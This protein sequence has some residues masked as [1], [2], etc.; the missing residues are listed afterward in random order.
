MGWLW[1]SDKDGDSGSSNNDPLKDLDPSLRAFLEKESPVKYKTSEAPPPD[2]TTGLDPRYAEASSQTSTP[3][4]AD[5]LTESAPSKSAFPDG[6]YAHLWSTYKPLSAVEN[7]AKTDQEKLLDV[8]EGFKERKAQIGRAAL[9][10]C[11]EE[12]WTVSECYRSGKVMDRLRLCHAENKS[13][14]RCYNMQAVR[15]VNL[16]RMKTKT[17]V[18]IA[19]PQ[20]FG[21]PFYL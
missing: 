12:Q 21:L 14:E 11:A 5:S 9:E 7:A 17:Y 13:F 18:C 8:I 4:I 2:P 19:F 20:S 10:N 16:T 15:F 6:R 3:S 1:G